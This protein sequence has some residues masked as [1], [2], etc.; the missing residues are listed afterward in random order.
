MPESWT[1][2]LVA[3]STIVSWNEACTAPRSVWAAAQ[4]KI[5]AASPAPMRRTARK[6]SREASPEPAAPGDD[7]KKGAQ[8][9]GRGPASLPPS[10]KRVLAVA[11]AAWVLAPSARRRVAPSGPDA[12]ASA[13]TAHSAAT[14]T[15]ERT[16]IMLQRFVF[17]HRHEAATVLIAPEV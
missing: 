9:Q 1:V 8:V 5:G 10:A 12:A 2:R 6:R 7:G 3:A 11:V 17:T 13:V 16:I 15:A 4:V 14:R